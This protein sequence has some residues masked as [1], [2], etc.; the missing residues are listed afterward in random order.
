M[1][2][3]HGFILTLVAWVLLAPAG[4]AASDLDEARDEVW[5]Q[6][7]TAGL[8]PGTPAPTNLALDAEGNLYVTDYTFDRVLK[9]SP[10]GVLLAQWGG[11]GAGPGQFSRPFGVTVD[12]H[13]AVY[14]VDQLNNRVQKF[15]PEGQFLAAWGAAGSAAGQLQTPFG[16]SSTPAGI[17]VADFRNDRVQLFAPDGQLLRVFGSTGSGA[18]QFL[19]PAGVAA[20]RDG[21]VYATDH[22]N[23][24]VQKFS[25]DGRFLA[26]VG[27]PSSTQAPASTPIATVSAAVAL[28]DAQLRRPE[29]LA[30]DRD[31]I[32][33]VADYGRDRIARFSPDGQFLGALGS[34]GQ[35]NGEL[36]GPKG[37]VVDSQADWVFVADT[38]N[39]RIQRFTLDGAFG[40]AWTLP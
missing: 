33:Y 11:Y 32:L 38:G 1:R 5:Y 31:G 19:R 37:V 17:Y 16:A 8:S 22:F 18:G 29:G 36:I 9:F 20:D 35:G 2:P 4:A 7:A 28:Q 6:A 12:E 14:V 39:G 3:W 26:Q 10:D 34:R 30:L 23:D 27:A 21:N 24:R 40:T 25:A 13:S 15:T